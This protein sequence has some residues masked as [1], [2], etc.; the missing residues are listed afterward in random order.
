MP[1]AIWLFLSA[2]LI[3]ND[4]KHRNGVLVALN[5]VAPLGYAERRRHADE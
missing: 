3:D 4:L 5:L 1:L 2:Y